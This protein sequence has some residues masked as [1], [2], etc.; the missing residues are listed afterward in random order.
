MQHKFRRHLHPLEEKILGK[1]PCYCIHCN[2]LIGL[3]DEFT[4]GDNLQCEWCL[5]DNHQQS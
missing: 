5:I 4:C 1:L 2:R 3:I